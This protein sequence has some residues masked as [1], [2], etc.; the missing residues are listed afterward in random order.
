MSY[1]SSLSEI[2]VKPYPGDK[3]VFEYILN[4]RENFFLK[5][6]EAEERCAVLSA[7]AD[8]S[9]ELFVEALKR[10]R[11]PI[12]R[13]MGGG[14]TVIL[15]R[16][17]LIISLGSFF[18]SPYNNR[19]YF[20]LI[21]EPLARALEGLSQ[22]KP[23]A[24]KGISD[25]AWRDY[26]ILGSSIR[27][28]GKFLLYQAALL[29]DCRRDIFDKYLPHPPREPDY[30]K[31]RGHSE[32]TVTLKELNP[33]LPPIERFCSLLSEKFPPLLKS[34]ISREIVE[35]STEDFQRLEASLNS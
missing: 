14:G 18:R 33:E 7:G 5:I 35:P 25:L 3:P 13:R 29:Y 15:D 8:V 2:E 27:R 22:V 32:F 12:Y 6:F 1:S 31:G 24:M 20:Q 4:S 21:Q 19:L 34:S 23:I 16:G 30:R 11:I 28:S 9:K 26:K 10:D 17:M